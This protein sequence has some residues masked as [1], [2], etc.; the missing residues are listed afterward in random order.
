MDKKIKS[1]YK[2]QSIFFISAIKWI[3]IS[4]FIGIIVGTVVALFIKLVSFGVSYVS[5][6]NYY[7][8]FL[9]IALFLSS[10]II[11]KFAPDAKGHGTEKAIETV[12]KNSGRSDFKI[13]PIKLVS[14]LITIIFGGSVGMEGPGTQ[15]GS[16]IASLVGKLF[17]M[18]DIDT[19][20]LVVCGISAGFVAVFGAPIGAAIF[21]AEVLYI[22]KI[23]YVSLL[24][25]VIASYASYFTGLYIGTSA[26]SF[27]IAF[28]PKYRITMFLKI[29]AF[30][31][32]IGI[33]ARFF[34]AFVNFVEKLFEKIKFYN[35]LKGIVGGLIIIVFVLLVGSNDYIG[36]GEEVLHRAMAGEKLNGFSSLF[37][38]FTTAI[39]LSSGGSGGILTPMLYIGSSL[40]NTWATIFNQNIA[41]FSAIGMAAFFGCCANTPIAAIIIALELF[42][43]STGIYTSIACVVAYLIMGHTSIYP[44]QILVTSKTPSIKYDESKELSDSTSIDVVLK[45]NFQKKLFGDKDKE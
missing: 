42:G 6:I 22:G 34:I 4:T 29:I 24:P 35:P 9:P 7:Y 26:L 14:T 28:V 19:K 33:A 25:S 11:I 43:H 12:H 37:K 2:E 17:K 39:T 15:I 10:F 41:F 27:S 45:Y 18:D 3:C 13:V 21:A 40:G 31:I 36:I 23:S 44:T 8:L 5:N 32:F 16:G 1:Y 30:G 38:M 20:R